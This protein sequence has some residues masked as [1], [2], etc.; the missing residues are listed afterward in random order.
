MHHF[1]KLANHIV[2]NYHQHYFVLQRSSIVHSNW[3]LLIGDI[4][5]FILLL[6]VIYAFFTKVCH[7]GHSVDCLNWNSFYKYVWLM[8]ILGFGA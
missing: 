1:I 8:F 5:I 3:F 7:R 2:N 4:S 6:L